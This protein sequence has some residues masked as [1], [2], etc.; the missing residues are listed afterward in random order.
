MHNIYLSLI[1]G[2]K[3]GIEF[4]FGE[5]LY[6]E[7]TFAMTLDLFVVRFTYTISKDE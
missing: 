2:M 3:F 6:E 5:D 1:S 4:Y 7:D